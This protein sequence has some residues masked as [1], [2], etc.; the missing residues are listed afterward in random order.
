[1]PLVQ[2]VEPLA[3]CPAHQGLIYLVGKTS[4]KLTVIPVHKVKQPHWVTNEHGEE[5]I[6][7]EEEVDA[8]VGPRTFVRVCLGPSKETRKKWV[9]NEYG[10]EEV[11]GEEVV[12]AWVVMRLEEAT[13]ELPPA[14]AELGTLSLEGTAFTWSYMDVEKSIVL[15]RSYDQCKTWKQWVERPQPEE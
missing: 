10:E 3:V 12:D 15:L 7:G 2:G 13:G 14:N 4:E 6:Q 9:T 1:M 11:V 8:T 5:E